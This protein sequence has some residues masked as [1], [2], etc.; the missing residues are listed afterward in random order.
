MRRLII[1]GG[2]K[3]QSRCKGVNFS[4]GQFSAFNRVSMAA[5]SWS[6]WRWVSTIPLP[7]QLGDCFFTYSGFASAFA[8]TPS[9]GMLWIEPGNYSAIGTYN[10]AITLKAPNGLIIL[11]Q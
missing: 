7:T 6:N 1:L 4:G 8:A 5:S 11:G 9:G 10:K 3:P 2:L